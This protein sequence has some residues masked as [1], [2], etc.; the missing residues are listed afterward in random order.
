MKISRNKDIISSELDGE[1]CLFD[2]EN[3]YYYNLNQTG[4]IIWKYIEQPKDFKDVIQYLISIFNVEK[5]ACIL[6]LKNFVISSNEK[7]IIDIQ[8]EI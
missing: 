5:D 7:N 3:A 4:S 1:V 2:P 8:E 6:Q